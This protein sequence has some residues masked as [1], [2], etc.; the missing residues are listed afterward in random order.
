VNAPV[1]SRLLA[2]ALMLLPLLTARLGAQHVL[3]VQDSDKFHVVRAADGSRPRVKKD[4]KI[5]TLSAYRYAL[6]DVPE[7]IPAFVTVRNVSVKVSYVTLHGGSDQI[8]ND[9][10]FDAEFETG[11]HLNDVFVVLALDTEEGGRRLFLWEVG[12]LK[13]NKEQ[14]V[15]II[16]PMDAA[17]GSGRYTFYLFSG[18][19]EILQSLISF[20]DREAGLNRMVAARIKDVQDA[21][22]KLFMGLGPDYP[23]SLRKQNAKGR[24]VISVRIGANGAVF[25]PVVKSATQPA[26]GEAALAAVK[27]WRF[28]PRVKN[29]YPVETVADV[30]IVFDAPEP[31]PG[32]T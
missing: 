10:H 23:P 19:A 24:A 16:A 9:F 15:H 20:G 6:K 4:G 25:D 28:L 5:V 32:K 3:L 13:P 12:E 17:V 27:L 1:L 8:N 21:P 2:P 22:P 7:Y 26:F 30:P 31:A 29:G 14:A 18:G 11:Y